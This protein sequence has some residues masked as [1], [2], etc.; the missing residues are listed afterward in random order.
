MAAN[1]SLVADNARITTTSARNVHQEIA[2]RVIVNLVTVRNIDIRALRMVNSN[3]T[4]ARNNNAT[5]HRKG[6]TD[7]RAQYNRSNSNIAAQE[8]NNR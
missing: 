7:R 3:K 8:M 1:S 2:S 4:A 5:A 6:K